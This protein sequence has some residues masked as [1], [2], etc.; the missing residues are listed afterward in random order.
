MSKIL[1]CKPQQIPNKEKNISIL[2]HPASYSCSWRK[3]FCLSFK[4]KQ[5]GCSAFPVFKKYT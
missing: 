5:F 4:T 1:V 2:P 3:L